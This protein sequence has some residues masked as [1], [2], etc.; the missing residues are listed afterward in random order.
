MGNPRTYAPG[1]WIK[2]VESGGFDYH[3]SGSYIMVLVGKFP[4][5]EPAPNAREIDLPRSGR[6]SIVDLARE[7]AKA[8]AHRAAIASAG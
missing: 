5:Q 7:I 3:V 6:V 1:E 2:V 8:E 4:N